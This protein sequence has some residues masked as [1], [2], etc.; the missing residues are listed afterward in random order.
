MTTERFGELLRRPRLLGAYNG[1][2]LEELVAA[3]PWC[4]PLRLL[5]YRKAVF[6]EAEDTDYWRSRAEPFLPRGALR[7]QERTLRLASP[8]RAEVHFDFG[9][10]GGLDVGNVPPRIV[11]PSTGRDQ[12]LD[13]EGQLDACILTASAAVDTA[14]WYLHRNGLI[15]EYGRPRPAPIEQLDS[16]KRWKRRRVRASWDDLLK[17]GIARDGKRKKKKRKASETP[18][19]TPEVASETLARLL[20]KQGHTSRAIKMYEQLSL[21]YP[22]KKSNFAARIADLRTTEA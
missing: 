15:M 18:A 10:A 5:R 3:Y 21:R 2:E 20:A 13:N 9:D 19:A 12:G 4:G 1:I 6:D 8:T 17:L 11:D 7:T 16:Y 22:A 14:D